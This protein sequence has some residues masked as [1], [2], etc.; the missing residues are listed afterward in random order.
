METVVIC[1]LQYM[2]DDLFRDYS[3]VLSEVTIELFSGCMVGS[4][5]GSLLPSMPTEH[6]PCC[7]LLSEMWECFFRRDGLFLCRK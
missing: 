4:H 6:R 7:F 1:V 3:S 2:K 5:N